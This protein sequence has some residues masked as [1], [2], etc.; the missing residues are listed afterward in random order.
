MAFLIQ[1]NRLLVTSINVYF[2]NKKVFG[3]VIV[4]LRSI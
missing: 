4:R 1:K 2:V 3:E